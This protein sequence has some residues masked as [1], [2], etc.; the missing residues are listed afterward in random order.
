RFAGG[1]AHDF[2]N[3][4]TG[5]LGYCDLALA[6]DTLADE[7]RED[8]SAIR[9]AAQRAAGLTSQILAFSRGPSA[10]PVALDLNAVVEELQPMLGRMI[11]EH[12]RLVSALSPGAGIVLADPGQMEQV[13]M[14]LA[15]NARD[16]M[17]DGGTL[18]LTT[19]DV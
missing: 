9:T 7:S 8:F 15:L 11:G 6:E 17:P 5:I 10:Q 16:A 2:N 18:T 12:I 19:S 13:I 4:L 3:L 14:N 1:I